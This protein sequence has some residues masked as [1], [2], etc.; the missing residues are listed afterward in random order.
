M[1]KMK[2]VTLLVIS[3]M[4]MALCLAACGGNGGNGGNSGQNTPD[5]GGAGGKQD[6]ATVEYTVTDEKEGAVMTLAIPDV[7][8]IAV[9]EISSRPGYRIVYPEGGWQ[10]DLWI[11][12]LNSEALA[13]KIKNGESVTYGN[14]TGSLE[15]G[16]WAAE[17]EFDF[18]QVPDKAYS[19]TA[20]YDLRPEDTYQPDDEAEL[21][22]YLE[23]K[24][25]K[26]IFENMKVELPQ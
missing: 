11:Y 14:N 25:V 13:D 24:Y 2:K 4:L 6:A 23:D 21:R 15:F 10:L 26:Q 8:G 17:G 16:S 7:E 9:S 19:I 3:M 20:K 22:G 5:A 1:K 18:G 12:T